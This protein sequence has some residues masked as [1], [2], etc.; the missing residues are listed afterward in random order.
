MRDF[1][2]SIPLWKY[3]IYC[4]GASLDTRLLVCLFR[5]WAYQ[6]GDGK[7]CQ[8]QSTE[9]SNKAK[10][11]DE[12]AT[13]LCGFRGVRE[14]K[15]GPK[16]DLWLPF[17]IGLCE[18]AVY[19]VLMHQ[20]LYVV[21]GAWLGIKTAGTWRIWSTSPTAFNRFLLGNLA[22][23]AFSYFLLRGYVAW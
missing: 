16:S 20:D 2:L 7:S 6:M 3:L 8:K 22:I 23:L 18:A 4:G 21:I 14:P 1:T 15:Y 10:F 5:A 9:T 19:P 12:F 11:S 17:V 13:A